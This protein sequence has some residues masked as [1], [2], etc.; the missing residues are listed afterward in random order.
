MDAPLYP[1]AQAFVMPERLPRRLNTRDVSIQ[2]LMTHPQ[3]RAVVLKQ[4]PE[5]EQRLGFPQLRP[6]LYNFAFRDLLQFGLVQ[7][8]DLA[9]ID[10]ELARLE[11]VR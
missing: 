4:L 2:D 5:I 6:H 7:E 8:P 10:E 11:P 3:G 1:P 9:R